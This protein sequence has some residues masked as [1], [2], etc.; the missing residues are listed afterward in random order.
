LDPVC[1]AWVVDGA[2][3]TIPPSCCGRFLAE[4]D[5]ESDVI[6]DKPLN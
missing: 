1:E 2:P 6:Y 5:F 3:M 4:H